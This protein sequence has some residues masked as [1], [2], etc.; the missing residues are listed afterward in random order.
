MTKTEI[1][2]KLK[3]IIATYAPASEA[4]NNLNEATDF[5]SDLKINSANLVDIVLD[6]EEE[7]GIEIDNASME[8]MLTVEAS[9]AIILA[10]IAQK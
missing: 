8:K 3:P 6:I 7:F 4:L 9:I 10:K 2:D 5:I 1:I